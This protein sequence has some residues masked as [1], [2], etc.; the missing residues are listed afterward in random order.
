MT[1]H[2]RLVFDFLPLPLWI[3]FWAAWGILSLVTRLDRYDIARMQERLGGAA[4]VGGSVIAM[5]APF[6]TGERLWWAPPWAFVAGLVAT[7]A[8]LVWAVVVMIGLARHVGAA[9]ATRRFGRLAA[10]GAY[11]L[12]RHP[13]YLGIVLAGWATALP[14][15]R[16]L[17]LGAAA[18]MTAGAILR[19][20]S[21]E[22]R[23]RLIHK[24][25]HATYCAQVPAFLPFPR[26]ARPAAPAA[27]PRGGSVPRM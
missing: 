14:A 4:M 27:R 17:A 15:G 18:A 5:A 23:L 12:V 13:A 24:A 11:G 19:L 9:Q 7:A 2:L 25:V 21:E 20:R 26:P 22:R 3:A 16:P 10:S 1:S 8:L 6:W